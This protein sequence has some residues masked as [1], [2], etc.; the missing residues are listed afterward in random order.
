VLYF[1]LPEEAMY[2][3]IAHNVQTGHPTYLWIWEP[4]SSFHQNVPM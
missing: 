2:N 4:C 3:K 1:W